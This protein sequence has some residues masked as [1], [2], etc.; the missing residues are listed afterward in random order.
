MN[1]QVTRPGHML[2]KGCWN[3]SSVSEAHPLSDEE[4]NRLEE[5][6]ALHLT[7]IMWF[8]VGAAVGTLATWV[9]LLISSL[10]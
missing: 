2:P 6:T 9:G 5:W 7:H 4:L 8:C 1:T 10:A 3:A